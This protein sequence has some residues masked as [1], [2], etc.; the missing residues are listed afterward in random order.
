MK[1]LKI[2]NLGVN[3]IRKSAGCFDNG[4]IVLNDEELETFNFYGPSR[5]EMHTLYDVIPYWLWGNTANDTTLFINRV[6]PV[7]ELIRQKIK[8]DMMTNQI[9]TETGI[10]LIN[11]IFKLNLK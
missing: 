1:K 8:Y 6:F 10:N 9:E 3:Y 5:K 4:N 7:S 11:N 2:L